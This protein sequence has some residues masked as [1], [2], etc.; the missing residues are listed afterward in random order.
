MVPFRAPRHLRFKLDRHT[1][2]PCQDP[3]EWAAWYETADRR[4]AETWV[5]KTRISTVFLGLNYSLFD[6]D[7]DPILFETMVFGSDELKDCRR[8]RRDRL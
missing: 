3:L 7:P 6:T 8:A 2:V 5:G 4:V 1:P